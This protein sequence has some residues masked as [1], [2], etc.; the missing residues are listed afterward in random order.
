VVRCG[1]AFNVNTRL[2]VFAAERNY[3]RMAILRSPSDPTVEP[4]VGI[5][6]AEEK[7]PSAQVVAS[8]TALIPEHSPWYARADLQERMSQILVNDPDAGH[9]DGT[10]A[11]WKSIPSPPD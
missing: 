7:D 4:L 6:L 1:F 8:K 10:L 9:P 11:G 3:M 2:Y 5:L